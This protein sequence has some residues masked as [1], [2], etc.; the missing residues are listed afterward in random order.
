MRSMNHPNLIKIYEVIEHTSKARVCVCGWGVWM[1]GM[2]VGQG[3]VGNTE[4]CCAPDPPPP[5]GPPAAGSLPAQ[6]HRT[7]AWP[8]YSCPPTPLHP[9]HLAALAAPCLQVVLVQEYAEAGPLAQPDQAMSEQLAQ[10]YF[11]QIVAGLAALHAQ[12][13]VRVAAHQEACCCS[14]S[15]ARTDAAG[16]AACPATPCFSPSLTPL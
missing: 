2:V 5:G 6:P 4:L 16:C 12:N 1:G 13:V 15:H 14:C 10:F 8:I 3:W 9:T 11:R 7:C